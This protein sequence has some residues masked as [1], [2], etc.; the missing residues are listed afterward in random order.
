MNDPECNIVAFR[1]VP[2]A[3]RGASPERLGSFQLDVRRELIRSGEFYIVPTAK[4]G[5]GAL[6][7]TVINPLT[8][9]SHLD[10]L[11]DALRRTGGS[12]SSAGAEIYRRRRA[13][14]HR[15]DVRSL[16]SM[17]FPRAV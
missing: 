15:P 8:T 17:Y 5:V 16:Y 12:C 4:D 13:A 2:E 14:R 11:I 7:A 1:H 9:E 3:L 10:A 6:R